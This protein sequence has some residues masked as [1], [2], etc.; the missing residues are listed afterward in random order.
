MLHEGPQRSELAKHALGA[1]LRL[2]GCSQIYLDFGLNIGDNLVALFEP[3]KV[4]ARASAKFNAIFGVNRSKTCAI[5]FEPNPAHKP[6]LRTL[7]N[8]LE[9]AGYR[10]AI[11]SAGL[12]NTSG[13]ATYWTDTA[14]HNL[15]RHEWG[16]SLLRWAANMGPEHSVTVPTITLDEFL[17]TFVRPTRSSNADGMRVGMKLDCEG[18]EYYVVPQA[19]DSLCRAV[20]VLW[21]E[22]HDRFFKPSWQGHKK[23]YQSRGRVEAIDASLKQI[24]SLR[25]QSPSRCLTDV[26][27][28]STT[29]RGRR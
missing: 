27:D 9:H 24:R 4:P 1:A 2:D 6:R 12:S 3:W 25:E 8:R 21:L 20:D 10:T 22:R 26:R 5:G 19:I 15:N 7:A 13:T 29:E 11:F 23:G 17:R 14:K 28:L 16:S 18:C